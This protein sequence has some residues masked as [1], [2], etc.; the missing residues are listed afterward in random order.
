MTTKTKTQKEIEKKRARREVEKIRAKS[1]STYVPQE[2]KKPMEFAFEGEKRSSFEYPVEIGN[3]IVEKKSDG[4]CVHIMIDKKFKGNDRIKIYSSQLNEWNTLCFP[5]IMP[6]LLKLPSGYYHGEMLGVSLDKKIFTSLDEFKA[7]ESRPK[8]NADNVNAELLAKYP[9][10]IDIFDAL[11]V[12]R[13]PL[14][15]TPF[16]DRRSRLEEVVEENPHLQLVEHYIV[17][18]AEDMQDKFINAIARGYEGLV[19]KDPDSLYVPG[20]RDSD[21]IKLKAFTTFDLAVLGFYQTPESRAE[22]KPFSAILVGTYNPNSKKFET[23]AKVKVGA[24]EDQKEIWRKVKRKV[25]TGADYEKVVAA[26]GKTFFSP[27]MQRIKRKIPDYVAAYSA[28]DSIAIVEIQSQD[29]TYSE[30][31]H[32]CGLKDGKAHSLRIPTFKQLRED[33]SRVQDLTTTKQIQEFYTG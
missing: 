30:N 31:W 20:S 29:V 15:A 7:I 27:D 10:K 14:L 9:L 33:K 32:S 13:K 11:R 18:D 5:D 17:R 2:P 23:L 21:W 3:T 26:Y 16:A 22:G 28:G 6:S 8:L 24:A 12:E 19:A 25:K 4:N 1:I